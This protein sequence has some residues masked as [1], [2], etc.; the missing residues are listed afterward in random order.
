MKSKILGIISLEDHKSP[1]NSVDGSAASKGYHTL[2]GPGDSALQNLP[3]S[4]FT[5][6]DCFMKLFDQME[7]ENSGLFT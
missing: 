2:Q 7:D 6:L 4:S 1:I 5:I 3:P